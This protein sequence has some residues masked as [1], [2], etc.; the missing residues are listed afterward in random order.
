MI[1]ESVVWDIKKSTEIELKRA[2]DR[3]NERDISVLT[4]KLNLLNLILEVE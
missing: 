4:G 1:N 2:S 3:N